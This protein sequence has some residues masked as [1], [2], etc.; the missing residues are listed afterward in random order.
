M[1]VPTKFFREPS[2]G[3]SLRSNL[4]SSTG[5]GAAFG[6]MVGVGETYFPAFALAI[7]LGEVAAGLISSLPMLAGGLLQ[8]V[9]L[10]AVDWL[11]SEKR[12]VLACAAIQGLAFIPLAVAGL[13]GSISLSTMLV[14]ASIYWA[15]GLASGPAWNTWMQSIVPSRL[16]AKYFAGRTRASQF[17]TLAAFIVGGLLLQWSRGAELELLAFAGLFATAWFFRMVSVLCLARQETLKD[18]ISD[19]QRPSRPSAMAEHESK[20]FVRTP[21]AD[22]SATGPI[23]SSGWKLLAFLVVMQGMVQISGPFFAPFL[24]EQLSYSYTQFVALLGVAFLSK[25]VA[26]SLWA[27]L[28]KKRGAGWLLWCGGLGIV[29]IAVLWCVSQNFVWLLFAQVLSGSVWAAYELGFFLLFFETLP[30]EKRTRMLTIYNFANTFAWCLGAA[31]GALILAQMGARHETYMLLFALSSIG[32]LFAVSLLLR[33]VPPS[34]S[35]K[36]P[37][38]N[39]G[40]RVLGMRPS[41]GGLDVPILPSIPNPPRMSSGNVGFATEASSR[42]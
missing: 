14:V 11:G 22:C 6:V 42:E 10:R 37:V 8:L 2:V 33:A 23:S 1:L 3:K 21:V 36:L 40:V 41:S 16:R 27:S 7:G 13:I 24:L 34:V 15:A 19:F 12:W 35:L 17:S 20:D 30:L 4:R 9:S 32:R 39:I 5:D 18:T 26:L 38:R 29:P 31:V 25:G 28:A